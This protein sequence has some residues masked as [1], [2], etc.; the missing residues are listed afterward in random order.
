[1]VER[2]WHAV[3]SDI[4][5][6]V[7]GQIMWNYNRSVDECAME[8]LQAVYG[9]ENAETMSKVYQAVR[10]CREPYCKKRYRGKSQTEWIKSYRKNKYG[11]RAVKA[12]RLLYSVKIPTWRVPALQTPNTPQGYMLDLERELKD[13]IAF[14]Q[15]LEPEN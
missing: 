11:E 6:Y 15:L 13:I 14:G 1:M 7:A 3:P 12:L 5:L 2:C 8:F 10:E 9:S 4:N